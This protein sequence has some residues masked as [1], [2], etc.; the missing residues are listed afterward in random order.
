[1]TTQTIVLLVIV[2]LIVVAAVW[3][4]SRRR[5]SEELREQFGPE[6][7]RTI[8]HIGDRRQAESELE[9]RRKRIRELN[10]LPLSGDDQSRFADQWH[11]TQAHFVDDPVGAIRDAD[12]LISELMQKRGYPVGDFEQ[13][14]ADISVDHPEVV[15]NYRAAHR[16]SMASDEGRATTEDLR[17]AVVHYRHLFEELL[18]LP[19]SARTDATT[20]TSRED[21]RARAS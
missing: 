3:M 12:R 5:R 17:K 18:E 2:A 11:V 15:V 19:D 7:E 6:Y 13:R 16:I 4:V 14:A 1:V 10:I 8:D 20:G 21:Y 9:A